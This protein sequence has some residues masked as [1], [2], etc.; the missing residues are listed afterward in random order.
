MDMGMQIGFISTRFSG[1]DGVSLEA[2]KWA[3]VFEAS[4]HDCY[5]FAGQVE[6]NPDRCMQVPQAH[7][8]HPQIQAIGN[9][10][11]GKTV[12]IPSTTEAIHQARATL[13]ARLHQFIKRFHL[14]LLVIQN[15]VTIPM[16]IPLGLAIT[17]TLAETGIPTIAHHHDFAWERG[18][19]ARNCISDYLQM[20]FPP[21]LPNMEHVVINSAA[22]VELAHRHGLS[23]TLIP[24]VINFTHPPQIDRSGKS[25]RADHGFSDSDIIILQPTRVIQRKGI[26]IAID[27]VRQLEDHRCKLLVSHEAGDEGFQY[28]RWLEER[29]QDQG[30]DLRF[31]ARPIRSPWDDMA[32]DGDD[33]SLWDMYA[34]ADFVT[35]PS[36]S[37]GFGN[38]FLEAVYFR[39]PLL[40][41]RYSTFIRDIE[42]LGF[43]LVMVDGYVDKNAVRGVHGILMDSDRRRESGEHNYRL[44]SRH[45][46]YGV[47][48]SRLD[49]IL[50][51]LFGT[52][53][54][55]RVTP[56]FADNVV[57][58]PPHRPNPGWQSDRAIR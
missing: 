5:W 40:V 38:A 25:F 35:F 51:I 39:K 49:G 27:M 33:F 29:A 46:S 55:L 8:R 16:N 43:E 18:R 31:L 6:G 34:N 22:R 26:E 17:E 15:A 45:F 9:D 21:K 12:R 11:F 19:F 42:P 41:N 3:E 32:S 4:G 23:S 36:L 24:N 56:E 28:A 58:F 1:T 13:K 30:V 37:E 2:K 10:V 20:A 7:F 52:S 47:L 54:N 14:D 44:A 57:N 50:K 48:R 53:T